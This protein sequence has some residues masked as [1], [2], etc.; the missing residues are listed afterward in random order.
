M[1]T[2]LLVAHVEE[3]AFVARVDPP[4]SMVVLSSYLCVPLYCVQEVLFFPAMKPDTSKEE[5]KDTAINDG[6]IESS[7]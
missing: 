4:T 6:M 1:R 2:L 3:L 5:G 7:V